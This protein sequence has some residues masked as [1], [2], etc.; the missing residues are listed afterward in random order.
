MVEQVDPG[1]RLPGRRAA[2]VGLDVAEP[3]PSGP[4]DRPVRQR[5][6]GD[7]AH[8]RD[9]GVGEERVEEE[10]AEVA[11]GAGQA[12]VDLTAS[13]TDSARSISTSVWVAITE[14]RSN[15]RGTAGGT[16]QLV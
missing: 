4:T 9:V 5:S 2:Q 11:G 16:A 1:E 10:P 12:D 14:V 15:G 8:R 7:R 13:K 6:S 3:G